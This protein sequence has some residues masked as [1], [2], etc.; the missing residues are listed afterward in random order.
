MAEAKDI[1]LQR[2][3]TPRVY[4]NM[5]VFLAAES[6]QLDGLKEA[7]RSSLAW[8]GI[9]KDT[10]R[11]NLTQRDSALA[12]AKVA[13]AAE[14]VKT[15]LKETWCYLLYPM[16]DG[17][18][19]DVEW[20]ASK[21]PAQDG[22]LSRASKKL[23]SDEGLLPELGPA[24][25]DRE[26][27]KY[28]WNGKNH[29]SL[30]DLWEYLNRYIYLPRV[31][32]RNVLIKA[33]R[34]SVGA[35]VPGPFAYAER[36]DE[37]SG[38]YIGLVLQNGGNAAIVIDS[39]SL[40]VKPEVAERQSKETTAVAENPVDPDQTAIKQAAEQTGLQQ[41]VTVVQP[42]REPTRFIGTVMISADRP[43]HEM[44]QIVEAIIEQLTILPGS[45]VSL[46]LEID[47]D[48]PNGLDR[49]K[50]RTLLENANTLGFID[51]VIK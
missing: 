25:L 40:I 7:M 44:R 43:A 17:A 8:A 36:W 46:K 45:E 1:L 19:A 22:L 48:V 27:Q 2:G 6:R 26:L 30:R 9:V 38:R 49:S 41:T 39:D 31:K 13:E 37:K 10:D 18:Q 21:V 16:Q 4:R 29:L 32:D 34:A 47:A 23:A 50:V 28:I 11:L 12:K 14:T 33:V 15:R 42:E 51:K 5:L 3:S 24:R 35:M 20:I